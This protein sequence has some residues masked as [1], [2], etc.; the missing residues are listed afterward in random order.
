MSGPLTVNGE[1]DNEF[2]KP[3]DPD[4]DVTNLGGENPDQDN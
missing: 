1:A 2:V 3:T 4:N